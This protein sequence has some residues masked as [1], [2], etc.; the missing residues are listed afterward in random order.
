MDRTLLEVN[1]G[2]V[3]VRDEWR[4]GRM[5]FA[6]TARAFAYLL[7]YRVG[8]SSGMDDAYRWAA[9]RLSGMSVDEVES[10]TRSWYEA[11][12]AH[13]VR[14][15]ARSCLESHRSAGRRIVLAT[16]APGHSAA[17]ACTLLGID[18]YVATEFEI[19]DGVFTGEIQTMGLGDHKLT[20][21]RTW[22]EAQG[23]DLSTSWFYTDSV[24]DRALMEA[25]AHPVAVHPDGPLR[26]LAKRNGWPIV[27]WD[28]AG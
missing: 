1:S 7:R 5:S 13:R 24:T 15:G 12:I 25:V 3:W 2:N 21:V 28:E 6:D 20:C 18:D 4:A 26:R 17:A 10:V 14:P 11:R 23:I 16:S 9:R 8:I 27:N 22:S 19:R